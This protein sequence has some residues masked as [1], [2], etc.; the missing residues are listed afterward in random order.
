MAHGCSV[1]WVRLCKML[2]M[3]HSWFGLKVLPSVE[4][5]EKE[6]MDYS[7]FTEVW[8]HPSQVTLL[9]AGFGRTPPRGVRSILR[10]YYF[11]RPV[12]N[13]LVYYLLSRSNGELKHTMG[14]QALSIIYITGYR[15][16]GISLCHEL[17]SDPA[18]GPYSLQ[19]FEGGVQKTEHVVC[20][21]DVTWTVRGVG[22]GHS[23]SPQ[24]TSS[25]QDS[26][27]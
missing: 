10:K 21:R 7:S 6:R 19:S 3:D 26:S 14:T 25:L 17:I 9:G 22:S 24:L 8:K 2:Q 18:L 15:K 5:K 1:P 12:S 23:V 4:A 16:W 13:A 20:R 27:L 11:L